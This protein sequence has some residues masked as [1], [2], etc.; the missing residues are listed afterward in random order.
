[1]T[2]QKT[3]SVVEAFFILLRAGLW[4]KEPD[5]LS[6]FPLSVDEW[7]N[8]FV[9][10]R[11][12]TVTALVYQ[13]VCLLPE[14]FFPPQDLLLK[15]VSAV[16]AI[17]KLNAGMNRCLDGLYCVFVQNGLEPVLQ[18][19]QGVASFYKN[20]LSR[21]SGDIDLY[22][23][24]RGEM[25]KA[26]NI[27]R[28]HGGKVSEM[29][30]GSYKFRFRNTDVEIHPFLI[31][32]ANPF[33]RR[34]IEEI[35]NSSGYKKICLNG[36]K[37]E[38]YVASPLVNL[39]LLNTHILKH[40]LGWGIGV[41]QLCDMAMACYSLNGS[42]SNNDMQYYCKKLGLTKWT[43]LL[44]AFMAD[45]LGL[46]EKCMLFDEREKSAVI[47][48]NIILE[49][50]NFGMD[51]DDRKTEGKSKIMRKFNTMGAFC[52]NVGFS[53]KYAP[54]EGFWIFAGLVKGQL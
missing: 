43:R 37:N 40:A 36:C 28:M 16:D 20:P 52:N 3:D 4:E 29:S 44:N 26:V 27:V 22:F 41:R 35:E 23:P 6:V 10:A 24:R 54:A 2:I 33:K 46:D 17:E 31:D 5:C 13:G 51:K 19:G 30:D 14:D 12:Q 42:Y 8:L 45:F 47:L 32:I 49:S 18:K 50:G 11:K 34:Y 15:W 1:M 53:L 7:E 39:L 9:M 48:K 21:E 25:Q 38:I